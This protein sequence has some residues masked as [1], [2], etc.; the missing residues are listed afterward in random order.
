MKPSLSMLCRAVLS[1]ALLVSAAAFSAQTQIAQVPLLNITGTGTVKPNL[2]LLFDNSGS[3]DQSYTP[4]YVNDALCRGAA[5]LA[6]RIVNCAPGH[7]PYM[8]A[9]FNKQY[10][11][12]AIL[13]AV[14]VRADGTFYPSQTSAATTGTAYRMA[15][16]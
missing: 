7:P 6:D 14:P 5:T 2:M 13:Y 1:L 11:N 3:M 12:P 9:D 16:L 10:Y 4:D 15:G 8:S